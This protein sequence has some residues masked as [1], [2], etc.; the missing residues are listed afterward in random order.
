MYYTSKLLKLNARI[1]SYL[2]LIQ[3]ANDRYKDKKDVIQMY[4]D[5]FKWIKPLNYSFN[6]RYMERMKVL[7]FWLVSR[8]QD[9][10]TEF[11]EVNI[12]QLKKEL[13]LSNNEVSTIDL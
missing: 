5:S 3:K 12:N 6:I 4:D 1:A 10:I 9:V 13:T 11:N 8:M 2:E 7:S